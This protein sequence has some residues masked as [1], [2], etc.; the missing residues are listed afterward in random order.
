MRY[1]EL[2]PG[3]C[4]ALIWNSEDDT[5][6]FLLR[7]D[8]VNDPL[9]WCLPGGHLE[10]GEAS[11]RGVLREVLEEVGH[12]LDGHPI[13]LLSESETQLPRFRHRN[14]AIRVDKAFEP[15]LN[16]EHVEHR[17]A[18]L[19]DMPQPAVWYLGML[20]SNDEAGKRLKR[21]QD[22]LRKAG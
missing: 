8:L 2:V 14:Y 17:W 12:D 19:E 21:W 20:L 7:S 11:D 9:Q 4:S 1:D 18:T 15:R 5:Y 6:L 3:G 10:T 22:G 16:W 13:E